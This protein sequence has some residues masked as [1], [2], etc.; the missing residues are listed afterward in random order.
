MSRLCR[1]LLMTGTL[2][3][4]PFTSLSKTGALLLRPLYV[5]DS[6]QTNDES[7][8]MTL[9]MCIGSISVLIMPVMTLLIVEIFVF[10]LIALCGLYCVHS[11]FSL[12][13][14]PGLVALHLLLP[15][16]EGGH[17]FWARFAAISSYVSQCL[18]PE[19][20]TSFFCLLGETNPS[21]CF[22]LSLPS[23]RISALLSAH[24]A[25][26][27]GRDCWQMNTTPMSHN[28]MFFF[29]GRWGV[30]LYHR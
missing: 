28:R 18:R 29:T 3:L 10:M 30:S 24:S 17:L 6:V 23:L 19:M 12:V 7:P 8:P 9:R 13:L 21:C 22:F 16:C 15:L 14:F 20:W 27:A 11:L 4:S 2:A 1:V 25:L 26:V 5:I